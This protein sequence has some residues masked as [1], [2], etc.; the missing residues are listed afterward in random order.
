M[1][2]NRDFSARLVIYGLS[3]ETKKEHVLK[4]LE[5]EIKFIKSNNDVSPTMYTSKL[6]K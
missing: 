1:K 2:K 4:W 5:K 6:M 3:K